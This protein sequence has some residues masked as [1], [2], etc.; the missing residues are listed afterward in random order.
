MADTISYEFHR[1]GTKEYTCRGHQIGLMKYVVKPH[2]VGHFEFWNSWS[3]VCPWADDLVTKED[4]GKIDAMA[5]SVA[6]YLIA[7]GRL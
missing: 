2:D 1:D 6:N 3:S 5:L 7:T 4:I